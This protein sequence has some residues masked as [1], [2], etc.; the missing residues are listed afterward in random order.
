[1]N[2]ITCTC[3]CA[4]AVL[5]SLGQDTT[6]QQD[7][8]TMR[9]TIEQNK[10][11][12]VQMRK[13][14][15]ANTQRKRKFRE[16]GLQYLKAFHS[17][18]VEA[19]VRTQRPLGRAMHSV[20]HSKHVAIHILQIS[21]AGTWAMAEGA[22][23]CTWA[24]TFVFVTKLQLV[25]LHAH[26]LQFLHDERCLVHTSA[27]KR[28]M[29]SINVRVLFKM[30]RQMGH[31]TC[32][33]LKLGMQNASQKVCADNNPTSSCIASKD[34][35]YASSPHATT[36]LPAS[37]LRNRSLVRFKPHTLVRLEASRLENELAPG[38]VLEIGCMTQR[39]S[40]NGGKSPMS[41]VQF[42]CLTH[43]GIWLCP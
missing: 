32:T 37:G 15:C 4:P 36:R 2:Q 14:S 39:G 42:N 25:P 18:T 41:R 16:M 38:F 20:V 26:I 1:M 34:T 8:L 10:F 19:L 23:C 21:C 31:F 17:L 6:H 9:I 29:H 24:V 11:L 28:C 27:Q 22:R 5:L 33:T 13:Q 30:P 7:L 12:H 35:L 3:A 40:L 43:F